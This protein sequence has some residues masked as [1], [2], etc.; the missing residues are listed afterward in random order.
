MK[1]KRLHIY[2]NIYVETN[3]KLFKKPKYILVKEVIENVFS[4]L[5]LYDF[6]NSIYQINLIR[7]KMKNPIDGI[8]FEEKVEPLRM[9]AYGMLYIINNKIKQKEIDKIKKII[10]PIYDSKLLYEKL[11]EGDEK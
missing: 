6:C 3:K 8:I 2:E 4:P 5:R 1:I 7:E 9:D 11:T 10:S